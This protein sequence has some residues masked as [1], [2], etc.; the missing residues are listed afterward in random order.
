MKKPLV[1][2]DS[3]YLKDRGS[4]G[5]LHAPSAE[6]NL[7]PIKDV[8]AKILPVKGDVLELASGT[9]QHIVAF[10]AQWPGLNWQPS[11]VDAERLSSVQAW[12]GQLNL[13]NLRKVQR[14]DAVSGWADHSQ[15]YDFI[16][17]V[18]LLH[19]ISSSDA[20]CV[21]SG[22]ANALNPGGQVM[23]YGPF[24]DRGQ[25]R[26]EGDATFHANLISQD[27]EIGYKDADWVQDQF[28][29]AGLENAKGIKMPAN[30]LILH[31]RLVG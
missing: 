21:V 25:F 12:A 18:N 26:S 20:A 31:A 10:A 1:M 17:V 11:D 4:D 15:K 24:L 13:P 8:L 2:P 6:R 5:R 14:L 27:P 30:N 28:E 29:L 23:V 19:L 16:Y 7:D 9:G 3:P 22:M